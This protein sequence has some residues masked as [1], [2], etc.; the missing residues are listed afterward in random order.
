MAQNNTGI[1]FVVN[2]GQFG[3]LLIFQG[4]FQFA[5]K[6][7]EQVTLAISIV[8]KRISE[9]KIKF[10]ESYKLEEHKQCRVAHF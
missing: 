2:N 8:V 7:I 3:P 1:T 5:L 10:H 4:I 6:A 9:M